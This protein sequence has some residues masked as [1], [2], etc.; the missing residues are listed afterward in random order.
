M[1]W[2]QKLSSA[3]C[4]N[5]KT[6]LSIDFLARVAIFLSSLCIL[7]LWVSFIL[8]DFF[9]FSI[10]SNRLAILSNGLWKISTTFIDV[11]A[12]RGKDIL[13]ECS[14]SVQRYNNHLH[15]ELTLNHFVVRAPRM[16]I[17][18]HLLYGSFTIHTE[19]SDFDRNLLTIFF[20]F[21]W[22]SSTLFNFS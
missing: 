16:S 4:S 15:R 9:F 7:H 13:S 22:I 11:I 18:I 10:F 17:A 5:N 20:L 12:P 19:C 6:H 21:I 14:T 8:C 2:T 3:K 1:R